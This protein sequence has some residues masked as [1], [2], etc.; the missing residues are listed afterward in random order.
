[1]RKYGLAYHENAGIVLSLRIK[2]PKIPLRKEVRAKSGERIVQ[3]LSNDL[4][5]ILILVLLVYWEVGKTT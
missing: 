4:L 3:K 1:M 2:C 5:L